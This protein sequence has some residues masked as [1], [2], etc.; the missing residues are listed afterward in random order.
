MLFRKL[1]APF[2]PEWVQS[3]NELQLGLRIH[4]GFSPMACPKTTKKPH[5]KIGGL[6]GLLLATSSGMHCVF[7]EHVSLSVNTGIPNLHDG[8]SGEEAKLS[9]VV[10]QLIDNIFDDLHSIIRT[11][12]HRNSVFFDEEIERRQMV[13][14]EALR[15]L[16]RRQLVCCDIE[17]RP[18]QAFSIGEKWIPIDEKTPGLHSWISALFRIPFGFGPNHPLHGESYIVA[19]TVWRGTAGAITFDTLHTVGPITHWRPRLQ[20][21][22]CAEK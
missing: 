13:V 22:R 6:P 15:C 2:K 4:D 7:C 17:T 20:W 14:C 21:H 16:H 1:K 18:G 11:I 9:W 19:P 3:I 12:S 5:G 10:P 8:S